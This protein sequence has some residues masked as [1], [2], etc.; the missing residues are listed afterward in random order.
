METLEDQNHLSKKNEHFTSG[1]RWAVTW[2]RWADG[3]WSTPRP[4]RTW[5]VPAR[6]ETD[7]IKTI[8][9][10][11]GRWAHKTWGVLPP[12]D[13][14]C[15]S[16]RDFVWIAHRMFL[17]SLFRWALQLCRMHHGPLPFKGLCRLRRLTIVCLEN[18]DY[19]EANGILARFYCA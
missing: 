12:R 19:S 7:R 14:Y 10:D 17:G 3:W 5:T 8:D 16:N 4:C 13:R 1:D 9:A 2:C 18:I 6:G 15:G 11:S